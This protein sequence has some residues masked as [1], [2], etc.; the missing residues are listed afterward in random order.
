LKRS[1]TLAGLALALF[2]G[3]VAGYFLQ[4]WCADAQWRQVAAYDLLQEASSLNKLLQST[5][6]VGPDREVAELRYL[7][8][9]AQVPAAEP[10]IS[11]LRAAELDGLCALRNTFNSDP[12]GFRA[13][14]K[15]AKVVSLFAPYYEGLGPA[16]ESRLVA[17]GSFAP[18]ACKG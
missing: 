8:V 13:R 3:A 12:F 7:V 15:Q 1:L 2:V 9:L 14:P 11:Q 4:R 6:L 10:D 16:V 18:P 17:M 5:A